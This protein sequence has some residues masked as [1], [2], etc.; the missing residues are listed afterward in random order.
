MHTTW[1]NKLSQP[2][3]WRGKLDPEGRN[4]SR[5]PV[6]VEFIQAPEIEEMFLFCLTLTI[7]LYFRTVT[8]D[9]GIEA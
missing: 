4:Y 6:N 8:V 9:I 1:N 7:N 2:G 3:P 5:A